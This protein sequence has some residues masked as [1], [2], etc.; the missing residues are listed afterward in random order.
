MNSLEKI[1]DEL[2]KSGKLNLNLNSEDSAFGI[3][4]YLLGTHKGRI[5]LASTVQA[6]ISNG[7][8]ALKIEK[9]RTYLGSNKLD[10][11]KSVIDKIRPN[12]SNERSELYL[13]EAKYYTYLNQYIKVISIIKHALKETKLAPVSRVTLLQI[14]G[15]AYMCQNCYQQAVGI[16]EDAKNLA[17]IFPR[18]PSS[19]QISSC[20]IHSYAHLNRENKAREELLELKKRVSIIKDSDEWLARFL[21]YKR[22]L[23]GYNKFYATDEKKFTNLV[24]AKILSKWL[25]QINIYNKCVQELKDFNL[26][27]KV[28]HRYSDWTYITEG[29][30]ILFHN[31]IEFKRINKSS[32]MLKML[33]LLILGPVS[34]EVFF[35]EI[36]NLELKTETHILHIRAN[37]SKLRKYLPVNSLVLKDGIIHLI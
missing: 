1:E 21:I 29:S 20:L 18:L 26:S 30:I 37:L 36:W 16:L 33:T 3:V 19:Y 32:L 6:N 28:I 31:K 24:E 13:E 25:G 11:A 7:D 27:K 2:A 17:I 8:F 34:Q 15:H 9:V 10:E 5:D 35:K 4:S 22:A 23:A 12:S 14:L